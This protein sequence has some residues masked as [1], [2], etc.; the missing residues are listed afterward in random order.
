MNNKLNIEEIKYLIPDYI[1]GLLNDKDK[2]LVEGAIEESAEIRAFYEDVKSALN[3]VSSTKFEQP[4]GQYWNTLLP[5]I[6]ERIEAK[7]NKK[8]SWAKIAAIWKIIIPAA[9]ILL[10]FIVYQLLKSPENQMTKKE[11]KPTEN[12]Q[13]DSGSNSKQEIKQDNNQKIDTKEN[14]VAKENRLNNKS[15]KSSK[16]NKIINE[17]ENSYENVAQDN[18]SDF[19]ENIKENE[20]RENEDFASIDPD[21]I[22]IL[23]GNAIDGIDDETEGE[24]SKLS[25]NEKEQL[26]EDLMKTNL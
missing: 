7:S 21:D 4:T 22:S 23:A 12:I 16:K 10:I 24:L 6:H 26:I 2:L 15:P 3:F 13:K 11:L 19:K 9:A 8:F 25:N 14:N 20:N 5:R 1:T 18:K 17:Q